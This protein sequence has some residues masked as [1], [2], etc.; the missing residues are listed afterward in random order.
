MMKLYNKIFTAV[1][2][3]LLSQ[4]VSA[5]PFAFEG[6]SLGMGGVAVATADLATASWA[7]P[8]MLTNQRP[9]DNFSLLIGDDVLSVVWF[10]ILCW[11]PVSFR[12]QVVVS[13]SFRLLTG[14]LILLRHWIVVTTAEQNHNSCQNNNKRREISKHF[15]SH[16]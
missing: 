3:S 13:L 10:R 9:S 8:A 14:R 11:T 15:Q 12:L 6:R 7:N 2:V 4:S 1:A 16:K 5:I